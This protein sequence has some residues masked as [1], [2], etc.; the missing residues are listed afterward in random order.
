MLNI[1]CCSGDNKKHR[2]GGDKVL[3]AYLV[4]YEPKESEV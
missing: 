4:V 2:I 3:I 1:G